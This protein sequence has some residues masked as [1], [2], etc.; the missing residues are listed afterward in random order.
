MELCYRNPNFPGK[1]LNWVLNCGEVRTHTTYKITR[2][3]ENFNNQGIKILL[4]GE[5]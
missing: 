5:L 4:S 3:W 2:T 1:M